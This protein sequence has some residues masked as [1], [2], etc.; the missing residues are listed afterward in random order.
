VG[1]AVV[2]KIEG[3]HVLY[4]LLGFFGVMITV[5]MIFVYFALTSFSGLSEK[6]AYTKGINYNKAIEVFK[7]Q[8]ARGWQVQ[9]EAKSVGDQKS[10]F[11]LKL[12]DKQGAPI[13]GLKALVKMR[14]P[15]LESADFETEL[16]AKKGGYVA[17]IDFPSAGQ[18]DVVLLISGGGFETPYRLEKRI[19]VK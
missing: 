6:D 2:K 1:V 12:L 19:W 9:L 10:Q 7:A 13:T 16:M 11:F 3:R 8:Q 14:H 5:N 4:M 18:W 17:K 15:A